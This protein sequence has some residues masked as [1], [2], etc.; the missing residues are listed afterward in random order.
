MMDADPYFDG[1][2]PKPPPR[3][4]LRLVE[5]L[6]IIAILGVLVALLLPAT[7]SSRGAARRVQCVN[8]LK[9]I[10]LALH[11]YESAHGALPPARTLDASGRPL[12]SWR[13]LILPFLEQ[14]ALYRSID[15]ARPWDDPVNARAYQAM[16]SVF[17]CPG[18]DARPNTTTYLAI[19]GPLA[20]FHPDRPRRLEEIA[21]DGAATLMLIE[22]GPESAV[23]WM[24]PSDA[25]ESLVLGINATTRLD[26]AGGTNAAFVDGS[27]KFIAADQSAAERR[28]MMAISGR[29]RGPRGPEDPP[30]HAG[31][32]D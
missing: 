4:G 31:R 23:P 6:A 1:P 7:R 21:N 14:E 18:A 17:R 10:A 27:V 16:P 24:V 2:R 32:P 11:N 3:R 20:C 26:H 15:L 12:H 5:L 13:T 30:Q 19:V 8:N 28:R 25:D 22:A 9:Q 29:E